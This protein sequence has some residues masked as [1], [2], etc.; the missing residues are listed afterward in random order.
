VIQI[1]AWDT[2]R[3]ANSEARKFERNTA[4][5]MIVEKVVVG[6]RTKY[7]VRTGIFPTKEEAMNKLRQIPVYK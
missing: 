2:E 6:G 5:K 1:S 7:I 3:K 4:M